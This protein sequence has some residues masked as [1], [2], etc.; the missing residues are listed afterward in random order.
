MTAIPKSDSQGEDPIMIL[1]ERLRQSA[2]IS[3]AKE[4][5]PLGFP[6]EKNLY[7]RSAEALLSLTQERGRLREAL[8]GVMIGGN[9]L[10]N[11]LIQRVGPDFS[12]EHPPDMDTWIALEKLHSWHDV[13]VAW[14]A[15]M[16]ARA[17][18][19]KDQAS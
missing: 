11:I 2:R 6:I 14:A 12:L 18:L 4:M 17:A 10:A 5:N 7:W 8:S 1:V 3:T 19:H 9:H 15:I 13:W 16:R